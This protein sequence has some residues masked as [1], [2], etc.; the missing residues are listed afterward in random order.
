[1]ET[2]GSAERSS[3]PLEMRE[4]F[5]TISDGKYA[6][7][8]YSKFGKDRVDSEM[9]DFLSMDFFTRSGGG[10]GVTRL[11]KSLRKENLID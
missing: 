1:M 2:I 3:N 4:E 5:L 7:T 11:I 8:I 10:I 6:E 9:K